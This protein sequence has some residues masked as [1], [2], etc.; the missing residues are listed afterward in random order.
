MPTIHLTMKRKLVQQGVSTLMVSL[1][2]TWVKEQELKKGDEVVCEEEE[3]N[4]VIS[5][6]RVT[7]KA[8][9]T[10]TTSDPFLAKQIILNG[11][12]KGYHRI[13]LT[14]ADQKHID[15][16]EE[17]CHHNLLGFEVTKREGKH[18]I[19]EALS[20]PT[21]D[22][23]PLI[24]EKFFATFFDLFALVEEACEQ[25]STLNGA[26]LTS[27]EERI[28]KY[29]NFCRRLGACKTGLKA[30]FTSIFLNDMNHSQ[31]ELYHALKL[32][33]LPKVSPR[34]L[35]LIV[36]IRE[37]LMQIHQA[38]TR[39]DIAHIRLFLQHYSEVETQ[40]EALLKK[41]I[42]PFLVYRFLLS[43]RQLYRAVSPL[44]GLLV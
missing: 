11:Y 36:S 35:A 30:S 39:Q 26:S 16:V 10:I 8:S 6:D 27:L 17:L 29:S 22:Q 13:A 12:R 38:Y 18:C 42:E 9:L 33:K 31:R 20:E 5:K 34:I 28:L 23:Y 14:L 3:G 32:L 4:L 15:L 2:I 21:P 19:I 24:L 37:L 25:K 7:T 1:P 44:S 43:A 40:G 41:G